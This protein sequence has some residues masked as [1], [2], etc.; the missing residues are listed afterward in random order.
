[1]HAEIALARAANA[2]VVLAGTA[3]DHVVL[4][5]PLDLVVPGPGVHPVLARAAVPDVPVG[6]GV[7][8][9]VGAG[10]ELHAHERVERSARGSRE[11]V[12][13]R[14]APVAEVLRDPQ[15]VIA[16]AEEGDDPDDDACLAANHL[17]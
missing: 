15:R 3:I 7:A 14:E 4:G 1:M 8:G 17:V 5:A 11:A 9:D 12:G 16:T 10:A 6:T 13:R 2:D